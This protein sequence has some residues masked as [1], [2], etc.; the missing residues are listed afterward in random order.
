VNNNVNIIAIYPGT[1]D[2]ITN[3]HVDIIHRASKLFSH[4]TVAVANNI[5]KAP[6]FDIDTRCGFIRD[7]ITPLTNVT[8]CA[9]D[10]LL[11]DFA[12]QQRASVIVRGVRSVSDFEYELHMASANRELAPALETVL[13]AP[14]PQTHCISSSLVREIARFSGDVS[15]FVPKTVAKALAK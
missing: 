9:F 11:V 5:T 6:L 7:S 10:N 15:A 13:L 12:A 1:F 4:L 3:G 14:L 2:P 8:V